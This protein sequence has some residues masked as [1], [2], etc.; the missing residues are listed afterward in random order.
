M[1]ELL[2][3]WNVPTK[4]ITLDYKNEIVKYYEY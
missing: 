4:I 3:E 1:K 2:N